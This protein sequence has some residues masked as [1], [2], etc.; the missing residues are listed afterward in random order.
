MTDRFVLPWKGERTVGDNMGLNALVNI[1]LSLA[2]IGLAWWVLQAVKWDL[3]LR[4]PDS[5]QARLLIVFLALL[6]GS[7]VAAFLSDYLGWSLLLHTLF[8]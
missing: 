5:P 4:R 2:C 6:V 3:F 1:V 7:S 8:S